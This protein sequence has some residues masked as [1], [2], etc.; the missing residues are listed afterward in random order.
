MNRQLIKNIVYTWCVYTPQCICGSQRTALWSCSLLPSLFIFQGSKTGCQA[1]KEVYIY[2]YSCKS[3][4]SL[5][6]NYNLLSLCDQLVWF[7]LGK[8]ILP[9][10][11]QHSLVSCSFFFV[12]GWCLMSMSIGVIRVQV[13]FRQPCWW[14]IVRYNILKNKENIW[15]RLIHDK[16][17][18]I[19]KNPSNT[20]FKIQFMLSSNFRVFVLVGDGWL[21]RLNS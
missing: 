5:I 1:Y 3:M 17:G 21:I 7:L 2:I 6:C 14:D 19:K 12:C 18:K 13:I 4:Y 16:K 9:S 15:Y 10:C 11:S 20:Y 8:T